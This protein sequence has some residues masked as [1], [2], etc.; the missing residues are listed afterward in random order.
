MSVETELRN[1]NERLELLLNLTARITSSL[2]LREVLRAIA[3][4]IREVIHADGVA[5]ALPDAA[6]EKFRVF[7]MDFP[8]GKGVVK[9]ELLV[10][11]SPA[12]KKALDTLKPVVFDTRERNELPPEASDI[13][14]G[15]GIKGFCN[16]PLANHGRA[17]GILS[18]LRTTE[19]P[20]SS[21]DVDFLNRASGQIA[22]AIENALAYHEISELKDKL[23]QEKLYL[24]E[25]IHSEMSF[26]NIVGNSSPLKHVL[27]LVETVALSDSTVLLLGETGTGKEL[28]ARAIHDRSKRNDR[29]FVKLNC[30]AIPTGLLESE[31]F[32]HEKGAFT[33]AIT[34]KVGR[35]ELA[36]QGTLFL[37]EVG[38]IPIEIQPKLLRALQEREF[39]RLG[40]T[41]TR[42]VSV[43]LIAATNRDLEQMIADREFRSD[44]YYR[45]HVFP[46]RIPPLR[47]RREDIP[48]LVSYFVQKFAKQMQKKIEAI[49]P[50]VMKG[51]TAWDWPGNIRELENFIERAVILTRSKSLEAPLGEL[52]RMNPVELPRVGQPQLE[53]V[54]RERTGSRDDQTSVADE[55]ERKQRDEIIRALTACKGR[56]GGADGAAACLGMNRTTFLSRMKKFGIYARQYA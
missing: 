23:A 17:L 43:R 50:T 21:E 39:E 53:Q 10:T 19:T 29:T 3:A 6:S 32:G 24:E 26:E 8:H 25:E 41:H 11:P 36:D 28:I 47:D 55:Y 40:S 16:I 20:F 14:A 18:I 38:D 33:G 13:V 52:R 48:Q 5:V 9:E 42:K 31:L 49:S 15:E 1:Q 34:Q 30:A 2:D 51:L 7:A 44:L 22:I 4:N 37:D 46:I 56:V 35:M 54:A 12:V 45:L 27:E